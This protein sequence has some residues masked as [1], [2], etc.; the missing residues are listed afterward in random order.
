MKRLTI[1]LA[2][3]AIIYSCTDRT[4]SDGIR[5]ID[6]D[7]TG[8]E[9]IELNLADLEKTVL[10]YS[11]ESI[12]GD[13]KDLVCTDNGGYI[14][15]STTANSHR[16]MQ[17]DRDGRYIRDIGHQGRGPGEFLNIRSIFMLGDTLN[18]GSFQ[19]FNHILHRYIITPD[20]YTVIPSS[21]SGDLRHGIIDIT[22]T[23]DIP[24]RYIVKHIWNGTP[25]WSTPLYGIYDRDWNVVDT[26]EVKYP[27]GG[28]STAFPFSHV[29]GS[30][31]MAFIGS[32]TIYRTDGERIVPAIIYDLGR[33]DL[34]ADIKYNFA[35]RFEYNRSHPDDSTHLFHMCSM[36]SKDKV[37]AG[38]ST[39]STMLL[40]VNDM[41]SGKSTFYRIMGENGEIADLLYMFCTPEGKPC[42][43]FMPSDVSELN[44]AV[45]DLSS[46]GRISSTQE[47]TT[48][49]LRPP[50]MTRT[51]A[52]AL[53]WD[54][55][56][57]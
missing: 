39:T 32:D 41:R 16:L 46:L 28:Y 9:V 54:S 29:D 20:G 5:V 33:S 17:F 27:A 45:Y 13:I 51:G 21:E 10:E 30:I 52:S 6:A 18:V 47:N 36:I 48:I 24:N 35:N 42:G 19:G 7:L 2:A 25:G 56:R 44:P 55:A 31:Y 49:R 14:I 43:I 4:T 11:E 23:S 15:A 57:T 40:M 53:F 8:K 26:S 50:T 12:I 3:A 1:I 38:M 37:Y 34:P 22:A